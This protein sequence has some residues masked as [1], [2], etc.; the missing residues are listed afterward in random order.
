MHVKGSANRHFL[1]VA[2]PLIVASLISPLPGIVDTA[3]LGHLGAVGYLSAVAAGSAII[4]LII[5]SFSFLR[6]GATA[7]TARA[8]GNGD[9]PTCQLL[10]A[11]SLV[12]ALMLGTLI[13]LARD[14]LL[15]AAFILIE[16]PAANLA[17]SEAYVTIRIYGAP[18]VLGTFCLTGWLI[19]MQ[20]ARA[21]LLLLLLVNAL[22]VA[23]DFIFIL[24]LGLNSTGAAMASLIAEGFGFFLGLF[25]VL[26]LTRG[27]PPSATVA[28]S[29]LLK[30]LGRLKAYGALVT[31]NRHLLVRTACLI[32]IFTFFTAQGARQGADTLA[33]NAIL[34]QLFFLFSFGLDGFAQAT[35]ALT[36]QAVGAG[37]ERYF[38]QLCKLAAVWGFALAAVT[39]GLYLLCD[40]VIVRLFTDLDTVTNVALKHFAWLAAI[41]LAGVGAF[42]LD[43]ILLGA[44][45][46]R[47]MQNIMLVAAF[48]VFLPLWWFTRGMGNHGLWLAFV[49][50][51]TAR[52]LLMLLAFVF[53][54][55]QGWT[56]PI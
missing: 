25:I 46:T 43:G 27:F 33:A 11:Q 2:L 51:M 15:S 7:T 55:R 41:P 8:L 39:T 37:K 26:R 4:G 23:L 54:S 36:G 17:L 35:E 44:G 24:G 28:H 9:I 32:F 22:N 53:Y 6:M 34:M 30:Q 50:F 45:K 38:Y 3:I 16:P 31:V 1:S 40:H 48:M 5:W 52:T 14:L 56:R 21:A 29:Q 12:L 42:L 13:I 10:L 19:G 18:A 20:K 47:S 49:A